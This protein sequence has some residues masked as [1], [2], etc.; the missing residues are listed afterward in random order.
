MNKCRAITIVCLL[1]GFFHAKA[2]LSA[3]VPSGRVSDDGKRI[4]VLRPYAAT[5]MPDHAGY[6]ETQI[7]YPTNQDGT[8]IDIIKDFPESGIYS[9]P[10]RKLIHAIDWFA[11]RDNVV[12]SSDLF[13][14]V[15]VND[16]AESRGES[17]ALVFYKD[18]VETKTYDLTELLKHFRH[19]FFRPFT[20]HDWHNKWV[21]LV[22][23]SGDILT[24]TTIEREILG[25]KIGYFEKYQFDIST[26][27]ML[28]DTVSYGGLIIR[29]AVAGILFIVMGLLM[30]KTVKFFRRRTLKLR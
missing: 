27:K 12:S 29:V 1:C 23:L 22:E 9:L 4:L 16:L 13:H 30:T 2:L 24:V 10:D 17:W 5:N 28:S 21:D 14:I 19:I 11:L 20:S 3:P 25:Y 6:S 26:G 8:Q 18:C 7:Q 15:R